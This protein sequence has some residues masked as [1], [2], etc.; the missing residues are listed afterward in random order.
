[1]GSTFSFCF[2]FAAGQI[3]EGSELHRVCPRVHL[4]LFRA[5]TGTRGNGQDPEDVSG[6]DGIVPVSN[7][8]ESHFV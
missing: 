1:L 7:P 5:G 3:L 8:G 2:G 4:A 6:D